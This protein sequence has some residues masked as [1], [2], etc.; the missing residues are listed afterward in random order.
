MR[1]RLTNR[2]ANTEL[3]RRSSPRA[4]P[5]ARRSSVAITMPVDEPRTSLLPSSAGEMD[6][7]VFDPQ[8]A[9]L[10]PRFRAFH[11][12]LVRLKRIALRDPMALIETITAD[13]ETLDIRDA[14]GAARHAL[15]RMLER[16]EFDTSTERGAEGA[17]LF[18]EAAYAM[19]ALAD[20]VF[21]SIDWAGRDAWLDAMLEQSMFG[22]QI[23]GEDVF[24]RIDRML[25]ARTNTTM[26][27]ASV[28]LLVLSLGFEGQFRGRDRDKVSDYRK[29]L[30]R[31]LYR[32]DSM[33]AQPKLVPQAY[34]NTTSGERPVRLPYVQRWMLVLGVTI[35]LYLVA[36]EWVWHSMTQHIATTAADIVSMG[37]AR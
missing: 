19:A 36:S 7:G 34:E 12:E 21:L 37:G 27:L 16:F 35:V 3:D 30:Y 29:K 5:G 24:R 2:S 18:R 25:S 4:G 31:F 20:E 10:L 1:L 11:A 14:A 9:Y 8:R 28:Y 13:K 6:E 32:A 33:M 23:A 17:A 15:Q 22:T 26:E